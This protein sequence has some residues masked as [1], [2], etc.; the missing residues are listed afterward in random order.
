MAFH[1]R[2]LMRV[3]SIAARGQ[4]ITR[5]KSEINYNSLLILIMTLLSKGVEGHQAKNREN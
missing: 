5:M 1:S 4:P 3:Y 2:A